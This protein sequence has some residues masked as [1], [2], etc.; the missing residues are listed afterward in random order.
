MRKST[1]AQQALAKEIMEMPISKCREIKENAEAR[2]VCPENGTL[3]GVTKHYYDV[4]QL[5]T[6]ILKWINILFQDPIFKDPAWVITHRDLIP[7]PVDILRDCS[8]YREKHRDEEIM[9][10]TTAFYKLKL[11]ER[12]HEEICEK[13]DEKVTPQSIIK[14]LSSRISEFETESECQYE[15][16]VLQKTI[17]DFGDVS[18]RKNRQS[19]DDLSGTLKYAK[20]KLQMI[21]IESEAARVRALHQNCKVISL[22]EQGMEKGIITRTEVDVLNYRYVA[23]NKDTLCLRRVASWRCVGK[24]IGT[25]EAAARKIHDRAVEKIAK[26]VNQGRITL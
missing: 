24:Q 14:L 15:K 11:A 26:A 18:Q 25:T 7:D 16:A 21:E 17:E 9:N 12:T 1:K 4:I 10:L 5:M 2:Y 8:V 3:T 22:I 19:F 23:K 20:K 6:L 13:R